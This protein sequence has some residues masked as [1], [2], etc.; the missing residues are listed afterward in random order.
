MEKYK[1]VHENKFDLEKFMKEWNYS[2]GAIEWIEEY[3]VFPFVL[4]KKRV[5]ELNKHE[6]VN[7]ELTDGNLVQSQDG[8]YVLL[9]DVLNLFNTYY[10][11]AEE[12]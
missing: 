8:K 6:C 4:L 5:K 7:G 2:K 12:K 9:E 11:S 10:N 1:T 3:S